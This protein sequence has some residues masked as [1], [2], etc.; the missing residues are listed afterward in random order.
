M[1]HLK[2]LTE[3]SPKKHL[4]HPALTIDDFAR[5]LGTSKADI[6]SNC[7]KSIGQRDFS[8]AIPVT[9][10]RDGIVLKVLTTVN[11]PDLSTAGSRESKGKWDI[12]W[13]ENLEELSNKID[14][15]STLVPK[16]YRKGQPLRLDQNYVIPADPNFELNW[17]EIFRSWLFKTYLK[18]VEAIYEFGCGTGYNL[19]A[20]AKMFPDKNFYGLDWAAAS[21]EI[22][23]KL[24]KVYGWKMEGRIFDFFSPDTNLKINRDAAFLTV[25]ALEQTGQNYET[26]LQFVLRALPKICV[27]AEPVCEWY[28]Q[29][30]LVDYL[31]ILYHK[32]RNY[33]LNFPTRLAE[34]ERQGKAR[35]IKQKRAYFGSLYLEGWSQIIWQPI[36]S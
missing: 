30:N 16:Y 31:A 6:P 7:Q 28:D 35:I 23:N 8:Y 12:G 17:Y 13:S 20:L 21:K 29:N 19:V 11:S 4:A 1:T 34:L 27:H 10:E 18:E 36:P 24:A 25:G 5:L 15:L 9:Q 26:F 33:W 3:E 2:R 22:V 32:K 14:D